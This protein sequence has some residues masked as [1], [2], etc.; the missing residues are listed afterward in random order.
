M[1]LLDAHPDSGPA[2]VLAWLHGQ[3]A[4]ATTA[5]IVQATG[6]SPSAIYRVLASLDAA[7]LLERDTRYRPAGYQLAG[8]W[9]RPPLTRPVPYLS[10]SRRK[11]GET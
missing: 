1:D 2:R 3:A 7:G 10:G 8:A 5:A 6:A 9:P 4:P 11:A